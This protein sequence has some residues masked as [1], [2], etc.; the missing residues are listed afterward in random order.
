MSGVVENCGC[1]AFAVSPYGDHRRHCHRRAPKTVITFR[2]FWDGKDQ[3]GPSTCWP[4]TTTAD[5]C[6][7]WELQDAK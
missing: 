1:C 2:G 7:E 5:F 4:E 6:G 3:Y